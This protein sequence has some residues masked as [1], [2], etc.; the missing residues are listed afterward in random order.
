M[1]DFR[2]REARVGD[3][4]IHGDVV[5]GGAAAVEAHGA[6]VDDLLGS[7]RRRAVDLAA[8]AELGVLVGAHDARLRLPQRS[9][10]FLRIVADGGDDSHSRDHDASHM[11]TLSCSCPVSFGPNLCVVCQKGIKAP[12]WRYP[13][14]YQKLL[15]PYTTKGAF[16]RGAFRLRAFRTLLGPDGH[17]AVTGSGFEQSDPQITGFIDA[18]SVGFK[19]AIGNAK[20]QF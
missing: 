11:I 13:L 9:D 17:K 5:P 4:L 2:R 3:G 16:A 15:G 7:E 6:A 10:D 1:R 12:S 14:L 18:A 8:K 20:H 19:P